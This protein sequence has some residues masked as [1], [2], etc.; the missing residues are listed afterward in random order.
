MSSSPEMENETNGIENPGKDILLKIKDK[1][2]FLGWIAGLLLMGGLLWALTGHVREISLMQSV[3]RVFILHDD[4]RRLAAP[5]HVRRS[6]GK[7]SPLGNWYSQAN[8]ENTFFVFTIMGNGVSA[9]C[10]ASVS[11]EGT[12]LEIIP[13]SIHAAD[14]LKRLSP[15]IIQM[16]VRRIEALGLPEGRKNG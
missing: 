3:N 8:S 6:A 9:V 4:P 12:V 1:A 5:L 2:I 7:V 16:Y 11:R 10:G 14:A 15:G 13:V